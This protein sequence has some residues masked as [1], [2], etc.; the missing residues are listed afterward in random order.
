MK[1]A[2][3]SEHASPLATVGGADAGGQNVHV[4]A[5]SL[6]LAAQG[7]EVTVYTRRECPF[8]PEETAFAP[9]VTVVHVP[10]GP[11]KVM[12]KDD[13]LPWMPE[14]GRWLAR[15][16]KTDPPDVAHSHFWMSGLA[17]LAAARD[18]SVPV[19]HTFHAL[20][21]VKRRHQGKAD[22][23]PRE[24]IQAEAAVACQVDA[25]IATCADEVTELGRIRMPKRSVRVVPC[26]VDLSAFTPS[27]PRMDLH[28]GPVLL[29]IGRP[30]PRKGV[31]TTIQALSQVPGA[32][33]VVAGGDVTDPEVTRLARVAGRYGVADRVRFLGKVDRASVPSL[34]RSA[35]IVVSVPWYEPFGIV[36]LEAMA[37]GVPVVAS[38]VG[39]HLD[40]VVPGVTGLLVPP[41]QSSLLARAL[42]RLLA[43]PFLLAAYGIAAADRARSRY[44][45]NRIAAQT[46]AV[47]TDVLTAYRGGR[48]RAG[49]YPE[50]ETDVLASYRGGRERAGARLETGVA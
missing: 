30:V 39:G 32:T 43:D 14:F 2:M 15:R 1:I 46:A 36:P 34:M 12:A 42:R 28:P 27:G 19:V 21:T 47:Y 9:G 24:R 25:V 49:A 17:T 11:A 48:E 26:G 37:C 16:W 8:Q 4:A 44:D 18:T 13:L 35:D 7:H 6:A 20:G 23:S 5:L 40:T 45:W 50:T 29:A 22:T 31:E 10:A 3:V 38:A 41:R 33:L